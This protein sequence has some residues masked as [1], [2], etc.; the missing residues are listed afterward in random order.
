MTAKVALSEVARII[1]G[2]RHRL[3]GN[4]FVPAGFPAYGAGG[5]NGF[6]SSYEF[7][8]PA[9]VLSAIGARCGKCFLTSGK[10]SSLANTQIILPDPT[11]ADV[12]YLWYQLN[13]EASWLRSGTAQP[14]IKPSTVKS[15]PVL[16]APLPQQR[17][18]ADILD[19]AEA[20]R[21]KRKDTIA[22]TEE[23]LRS[24][25][26]EMFGDPVTN[27]KGWS[28]RALGDEA[29]RVTVGHVGPVSEHYIENGI[30]IFRTG[31]VGPGSLR[32]NNL[33]HVTR[34]FHETHPNSSVRA[35]DVLLTRH[36]LDRLHCA[37][38][39]ND[40]GEAQC[41]N[42]I[43]VRPG[44]RIRSEYVVATLSDAGVQRQLLGARVG[45]AQSVVNTRVLQNYALPLPP[46]E[47][48]T[49]FAAI[50]ES[51]RVLQA[52]CGAGIDAAEQL[53]GGLL[54][55]AFRGELVAPKGKQQLGLFGEGVLDART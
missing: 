25:F 43:L 10:W 38:V 29:E 33:L 2:G 15:R 40:N 37:V 35:G 9:V 36:V 18:I 44:R 11:K 54:Q 27:P 47:L 50:V 24:A 1:Q 30:P 5:V 26:L 28:R 34:A 6:L 21:R 17:R 48:Q 31:N 20:V 32:R 39:P 12:R 45:T 53:F 22:L 41:L 23:L 4:D 52:K 14:F 51:T 3:S 46:L 49:T 55:R 7:D 42:I 16:L 8:E 13:N 19:K